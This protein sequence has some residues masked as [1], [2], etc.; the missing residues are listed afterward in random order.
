MR[1][2]YVSKRITS[3][4]EL[5]NNV[6]GAYVALRSLYTSEKEIMYVSDNMLCYELT[7]NKPFTRYF[8]E[9]VHDG[10]AVLIDTGLVK[11]IETVSKTE[12]ILDLSDLF[13]SS[14]KATDEG[15][16]YT[17]IYPD[18]IY[19]IFNLE[20]KT[21]KFALCRYFIQML[22]TIN[23]NE[24]IYVGSG[25]GTEMIS[26]FVGYMT[27]EYLAK[28]TGISNDIG[29]NYTS[30]LEELELVYVYRHDKY[31]HK[32][33]TI[34][35]FTNHYGRYEDAEHIVQFAKE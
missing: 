15:D 26:N 5:D 7:G 23:F 19:K 17:I 28:I 1:F 13:I 27:S 3:N 11:V 29:L 20:G 30:I 21:D 10:L 31:I 24:G 2:I 22:G 9:S 6:I 34:K 18:E 35:S 14:V 12:Y 4:L 16:Y 8:K 33:G 25:G 32:D